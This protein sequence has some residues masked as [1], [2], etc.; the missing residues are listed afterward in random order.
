[1]TEFR[2]NYV[3]K[4]LNLYIYIWLI[5]IKW[6][7]L[8][9][10]LPCFHALSQVSVDNVR[11]RPALFILGTKFDMHGTEL[12]KA[13][14]PA[15]VKSPSSISNGAQYVTPDSKIY[16]EQVNMCR[17][18]SRNWFFCIKFVKRAVVGERRNTLVHLQ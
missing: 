13:G 1:V 12:E 6:P 10:F 4:I 17:F 15:P 11:F 18:S 7:S 3:L 5:I 14:F 2:P 9:C 8:L 16:C